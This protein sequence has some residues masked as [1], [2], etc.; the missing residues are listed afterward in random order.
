MR[1][2]GSVIRGTATAGRVGV[3]LIALVCLG[4]ES[5]EA[6]PRRPPVAAGG[7]YEII[8]EAEL[9]AYP[10]RVSTLVRGSLVLLTLGFSELRGPL[11]IIGASSLLAIAGSAGMMIYRARHRPNRWQEGE[12]RPQ[13]LDGTDEPA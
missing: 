4:P 5:S 1:R 9:V 12:S 7:G 6:Q 2:V 8:P 11:G 13:A 3:C 10:I